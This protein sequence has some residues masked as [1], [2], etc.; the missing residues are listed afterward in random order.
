MK[1]TGVLL[2]LLTA[3]LLFAFAAP[4]FADSDSAVYL[5]QTG[6]TADSYKTME[7]AFAALPKGGII[8]V[9]GTYVFAGESESAG[10]VTFP[11]SGGKVC[12]TSADPA[13]VSTLSFELGVKTRVQFMSP[14]ELADIHWNYDYAA[15]K[16]MDI[17]SGPSLT[18]GSGVTTSIGGDG[19]TGSSHIAF[20]GG[21]YK[22]ESAPAITE[23]D[24]SARNIKLTVNS[25]IWSYAQGGHSGSN[26]VPVGDVEINI[27]GDATILSYLQS[28][29]ANGS[30]VLGNVTTN[31]TGGYVGKLDFI[32]HG[33]DSDT[34][35]V[36]G[37]VTITITG[38]I[39]KDAYTARTAYEKLEGDL[40]V[41]IGGTAV[42]AP[43]KLDLTML[44]PEKKQIL[45]LSGTGSLDGLTGSAW[46]SVNVL[47]GAEFDF[48]GAWKAE[49][50]S[51]L[52]VED[53]AVLQLSA[54]NNAT[55]PAFNKVGAEGTGNVVLA[56]SHKIIAVDAKVA[57]EYVGGWNAHYRCTICDKYFTDEVG[58]NETTLEALSIPATGKLNHHEYDS[59]LDEGT[60]ILNVTGGQGNAISGNYLVACTKQGDCTIYDM[61]TGNEIANFHLGSFNAQT[62]PS[63][64]AADG[65]VAKDWENHS[66]QIMFGPNKFDENDPLPLLYVT[67]GNS[68][69]HDGTG[70]YIAKMAIERILYTEARG[71]YA[72]T[73]QIIEFN[74]FDNIP[75]QDGNPYKQ[76]NNNNNAENDVLTNMYDAATGKFMY[77]SG[78][79]YDAAKGYQKVGWGWPAWLVDSNPTADTEGKIYIKSAR[80]RTTRAYEP[81]NKETYGIGNYFDGGNAYIVTEFN[82]PALPASEK[83]AAYGATVTLYTKD[84]QDQFE[85]EY[86][87]G[88][89][90]GGTMYQGRIYFSYGNGK[91][92]D[93]SN[94]AY[95]KYVTNAIQVIDIASEKII[96]KLDITGTNMGGAREPECCSIWNGELMLGMNGPQGYEMYAVGYVA[97]KGD[98][99]EADCVHNI[100]TRKV[101][102]LCG[103]VLEET[104]LADSAMGHSLEHHPAVE[105]TTTVAGNIEYWHCKRCDQYFADA[106][107]TNEITREST[108]LGL[109]AKKTMDYTNIVVIACVLAVVAATGIVFVLKKRKK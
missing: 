100:I 14:V 15:G 48:M 74:D 93:A 65:T 105:S 61:L 9:V 95:A 109:L 68:G 5:D 22:A 90:Q 3:V 73:V 84:I 25:G 23:N 81:L 106:Q 108:A 29:G 2:A 18:I 42:V 16:N 28:T 103:E 19:T 41:T 27:G 45:N 60:H 33:N 99:S 69:K 12:I 26:G 56:T 94:A 30:D 40:T 104:E 54:A 36:Y 49:Q 87:Y 67:T 44:N 46:D 91:N 76:M 58:L 20:R 63:G 86:D 11:T 72:E 8:K 101:C 57:G 71:W 34:A 55:T 53:G 88:F 17:Y 39:V 78:N 32:G 47:S 31:I 52:N 79:G 89:T 97:V 51:A 4:V 37:N 24:Y 83:D 75:A 82:M 80:F 59:N 35:T 98:T 50:A 96:A 21:W 107:G 92:A 43:I 1:K 6:S 10:L 77:V 13:N 66:N 38:G 102:A 7:D 85:V 70:A 62:L 64:T